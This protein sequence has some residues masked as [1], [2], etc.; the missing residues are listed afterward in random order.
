[1][2]QNEDAEFVPTPLTAAELDAR[3]LAA[4]ERRTE[5]NAK[6]RAETRDLLALVERKRRLIARS[7]QILVELQEEQ[8]AIH[9]EV[10]RLLTPEEQVNFAAISSR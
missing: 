5:V 10:K 2:Q 1:M 3:I 4:S 6:V 7:E 8:E 9:A